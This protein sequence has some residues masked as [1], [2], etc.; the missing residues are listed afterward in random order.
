MAVSETDHPLR[1]WRLSFDPVVTLVSLASDVGV[2]PSHLSEIERGFNNPS[3][4]LAVKLKKR[5]GIPAEQLLPD[6]S[7]M[8]KTLQALSEAA[9]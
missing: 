7:E 2:T 1:R 9:E 4:S 5:T 6:L 3:V 8:L